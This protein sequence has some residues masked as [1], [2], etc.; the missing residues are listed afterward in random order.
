M[1]ATGTGLPSSPPSMSDDTAHCRASSSTEA[2]EVGNGGNDALGQQHYNA[3]WGK[4]NKGK[5]TKKFNRLSEDNDDV[6][7]QLAHLSSSEERMPTG[8]PDHDVRATETTTTISTSFACTV[9]LCIF[10]SGVAVGSFTAGTFSSVA[11]EGGLA[12]RSEADALTTHTPSAQQSLSASLLPP[13]PPLQLAASPLPPCRPSVP[14]A[15]PPTQRQWPLPPPSLSRPAP[16]SS[17]AAAAAPY[18][19]IP[20]PPLPACPPPSTP[21]SVPPGSPNPHAP[22]PPLISPPPLSLPPPPSLCQTSRIGGHGCRALGFRGCEVQ[23]FGDSDHG[24]FVC[25]FDSSSTDVSDVLIPL[26]GTSYTGFYSQVTQSCRVADAPPVYCPW[27]SEAEVLRRA[28]M[29]SELWDAYVMQLYRTDTEHLALLPRI[30]Q[31]QMVYHTLLNGKPNGYRVSGRWEDG[32]F[33]GDPSTPFRQ[34]HPHQ[35]TATFYRPREPATAIANHTWVEV[36]HCGS[37]WE[38][39]DRMASS[40][41]YI[42]RGSSIFMNTGRTIAFDDHGGAARFFLGRECQDY[43][44]RTNLVQCDPANDWIDIGRA[45]IAAGYDSVQFL[46]HCDLECGRCAHE[47]AVFTAP[48][49]GACPSGVELRTGFNASVPCTCT[50]WAGCMSCQEFA[51]FQTIV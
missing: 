50:E 26:N 35:S 12:Q 17:H 2:G 27:A 43:D 31:V 30:D 42:Y 6:D 24:N 14:G 23:H 5:V 22:P 47:I 29:T 19:P 36:T 46:Q 28:G 1:P 18:G 51:T 11:L 33:Y 9:V 38:T 49:S 39:S 3:S 48:G 21:P 16:I 4:K 44:P 37:D 15:L 45:A 40:W 41:F 25:A 13:S 8:V 20:P 34:H 7:I 10:A 32:C